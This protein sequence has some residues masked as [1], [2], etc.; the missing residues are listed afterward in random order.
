M[1]GA[2]Q[3][4]EMVAKKQRQALE[5]VLKKVAKAVSSVMTS[6]KVLLMKKEK[7]RASTLLSFLR[8]R[9]QVRVTWQGTSKMIGVQIAS[10]LAGPRGGQHARI[11]MS[12][13]VRVLRFGL[14]ASLGEPGSV[15]RFGD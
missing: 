8:R 15:F 10:A 3:A 9:S 7:L 6:T 2:S 1:S 14:D 12:H 5:S 4:S 13:F 11:M